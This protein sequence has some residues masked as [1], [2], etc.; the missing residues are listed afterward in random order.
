MGRSQGAP[1]GAD[2]EAA[3]KGA[4]SE[5]PYRAPGVEH[6]Y[7]NAG[8]ALLAGIIDNVTEE[9]YQ[10]FMRTRIFARADL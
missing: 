5:Q 1:M 6:E 9:G 2:L 7:W 3:V 8:Y 4:L 10:D